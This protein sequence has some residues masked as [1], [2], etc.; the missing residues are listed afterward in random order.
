ME[1][2][3]EVIKN[4]DTKRLERDINDELTAFGY[5][6]ARDAKQNLS[7]NKTNN[8]GFLTNSIYVI[9]GRLK[10]EIGAGMEYAAYIEFGTR[11]FAAAYVNSLP[12]DWKTFAAKFRGSGTGTFA[13]MVAS[14][15]QWCKNKG[16]DDNAAYAIARKIL[17]EGIPAQPYLYP[18]YEK[19]RVEL[20]KRLKALANA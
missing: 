11:K 3:D 7:I 15:T 5:D 17:I 14:I 10:V 18:A 16:I 13:Q 6:V 9:P 19:N 12:P 2:F 4:L 20:I 8:L 1:G